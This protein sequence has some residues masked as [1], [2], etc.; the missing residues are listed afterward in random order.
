MRGER[1][2]GEFFNRIASFP[3]ASST[4]EDRLQPGPGLLGSAIKGN[5]AR[6]KHISD[7]S[8]AGLSYVCGVEA[9]SLNYPQVTDSQALVTEGSGQLRE[10]ELATTVH[11]G[12][13]G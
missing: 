8:G 11:G 3:P 2:L 9:H 12:L 13:H 5:F 7:Y 1:P 10:K 4:F 6:G